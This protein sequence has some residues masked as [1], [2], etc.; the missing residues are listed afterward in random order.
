MLLFFIF[1]SSLLHSPAS[2]YFFIMSIPESK[3]HVALGLP[4]LGVENTSRVPDEGAMG[5]DVDYFGN[6][7]NNRG[8]PSWSV[9]EYRRRYAD[10]L[11]T[12]W[13]WSDFF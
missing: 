12:Q 9:A 10:I 4:L 3:N 13:F 6:I 1:N 2:N 8:V 11:D 7:G 5:G